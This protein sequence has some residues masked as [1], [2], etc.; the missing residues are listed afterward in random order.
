MF[1]IAP[2]RLLRILIILSL[3][4]IAD[5]WLKDATIGIVNRSKLGR[6]ITPKIEQTF[7][8]G[9][10]TR[11]REKLSYLDIPKTTT[12]CYMYEANYSD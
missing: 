5:A 8:I 6:R 4:A 10:H 7:L 9:C 3:S 12:M 1:F 2:N 11:M